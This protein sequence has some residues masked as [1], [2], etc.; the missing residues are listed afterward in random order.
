MTASFREGENQTLSRVPEGLLDNSPAFQCRERV[1]TGQSPVGTTELS[2]TS[3]VPTGL[4][5][6][7]MPNPALKHRAIVKC[8]YGTIPHW[9]YSCGNLIC[10]RSGAGGENLEVWLFAFLP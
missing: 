7:F 1:A 4:V 6:L 10:A 9:N 5:V 8:P 2:M 3:A